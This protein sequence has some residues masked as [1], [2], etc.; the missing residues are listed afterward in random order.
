[1]SRKKPS[2]PVLVDYEHEQLKADSLTIAGLFDRPHKEV[3]RTIRRLASDGTLKPSDFEEI[4]GRSSA[5]IA[6]GGRWSSAPTYLDSWNRKQ[7]VF[8]LTERGFLIAMPFFRGKKAQEGQA[9]LVDEF[10]RL[11]K[12]IARS[13]K[14]RAS[15]DWQQARDSGKLVRRTETDVIKAFVDYATEQGSRNARMYYQNLTKATYKALFLLQHATKWQ[16][17]RELLDGPQLTL[18]ATAEQVVQQ[19]LRDGMARRMAYKEIYQLAVERL[20]AMS[21]LLPPKAQ[22]ALTALPAA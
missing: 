19:A 9:R 22:P 17:V 18:V 2:P 14:A 15:L 20:S 8:L 10:Q 3:L 11:R 4:D 6:A 21:G 7:P 1:M 12:Q 5:P 13:Q 16:G